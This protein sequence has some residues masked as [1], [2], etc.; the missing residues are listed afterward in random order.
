MP[1]LEQFRAQIASLLQ[2]PATQDEFGRLNTHYIEFDEEAH[3]TWVMFYDEVEEKIG[4]DQEYSTIK[5]VASKAAENAARIA[6]CLHVFTKPGISLISRS[7]MAAACSLM[8]WYLDEAVRFGQDAQVTEELNNAELLEGWL[9][10]H[11]KQARWAKQA[12]DMRVNMI[13]QKGPNALRGGKRIDDALELLRDH[14]RVRIIQL[15]GSKSKQVLIAPK[16]IE[17]DC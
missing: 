13:R 16:V 11:F 17:E 14:G 6:C 2:M 9:V 10:E 5:D 12:W 1:A 4:G 15:S 3:N 7:I 8:R